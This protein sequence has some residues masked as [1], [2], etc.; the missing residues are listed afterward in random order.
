MLYVQYGGSVKPESVA[1]Y[2]SCPDVDGALS[3]L[4]A[5]FSAR[6]ILSVIRRCEIMSKA[7]VALII[8]DGFA[9]QATKYLGMPL[10]Q[11]RNQQTLTGTGKSTTTNSNSGEDVGLPDGQMGNSEVG[12]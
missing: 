7:P 5:L 8:L 4:G 11:P 6:I 12:H 1:E 9:I 3:R 2:M 10:K